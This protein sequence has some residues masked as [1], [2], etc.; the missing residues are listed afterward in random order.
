MRADALMSEKLSTN[1]RGP[2]R[3]TDTRQFYPPRGGQDWF[4]GQI[5]QYNPSSA[6]NNYN[7]QPRPS[8]ATVHHYQAPSSNQNGQTNMTNQAGINQQGRQINELSDRQTNA[9]QQ[10]DGRTNIVTMEEFANKIQA[11]G[12]RFC[13][14]CLSMHPC[15]GRMTCIYCIADGNPPHTHSSSYHPNGQRTQMVNLAWRGPKSAL[16]TENTEGGENLSVTSKY[17]FLHELTDHPFLEKY[18]R[19]TCSERD[20]NILRPGFHRSKK[21][22]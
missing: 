3:Q 16:S 13:F 12:Q 11:N 6:N 18:L 1:Y 10:T 9:G 4:R 22:R 17:N 21:I 5:R 14:K 8:T 15:T 2:N 19:N 20:F 7:Q